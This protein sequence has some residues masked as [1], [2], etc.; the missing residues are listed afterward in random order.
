MAIF[1]ITNK[2]K[3]SSAPTQ[4][5]DVS[6]NLASGGTFTFTRAFFTTETTPKYSHPEGAAASKLRVDNLSVTSD[7]NFTIDGTTVAIGNEIDM[8]DIDNNLLVI[9]HNPAA[10]SPVDQ[11]LTMRFSL[12]DVNSNQFSLVS[13]I[14]KGSTVVISNTGPTTVGGNDKELGYGETLVF[15]RAMF[16][17]ETV[18]AYSDSEGDSADKLKIVSLPDQSSSGSV[19][20]QY[21]L[22]LNGVSVAVGDIIDFSDID[23]GLL[24]YVAENKSTQDFNASFDFEIAD[25]GSGIFKS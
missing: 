20:N 7:Y 5:G 6:F 22:K 3:V 8:A 11:S 1:A 4:V 9:V 16:T 25:S 18:P 21:G 14:V 24:T 23:S 13:G 10:L 19:S 12:S 15:T 17:T 2:G